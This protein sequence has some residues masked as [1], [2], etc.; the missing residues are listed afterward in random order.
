MVKGS[1]HRQILWIIVTVLVAAFIYGSYQYAV[2]SAY[3]VSSEKA[4]EMIQKN[5]VDVILDVRTDMERSTLGYYPGSVHLPRADLENRMMADYPNKDTRIIV[6]C[7]T[8]HRARMATD[9]LQKMGYHNARYIS[10]TY[11]SLM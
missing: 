5:N 6:Y 7:N 2:S 1:I 8:G 11:A 10:S 9:A 3:R 4:K